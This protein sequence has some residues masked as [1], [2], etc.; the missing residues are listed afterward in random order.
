MA[1]S[2]TV[3]ALQDWPTSRPTI[4]P[5]CRREK[6]NREQKL[7]RKSEFSL[8]NNVRGGGVAGCQIYR[9]PLSLSWF[10]HRYVYKTYV[11]SRTLFSLSKHFAPVL[12]S[13]RS[14]VDFFSSSCY[15]P[16]CLFLRVD[17]YSE[18]LEEHELQTAASRLLIKDFILT[19]FIIL[20]FSV[21]GVGGDV[22]SLQLPKQSLLRPP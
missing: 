21:W 7:G 5:I 8:V 16:S 20:F 22:F 4:G 19:F 10:C 3:I 13:S 11:G 15:N 12:D 18:D 2:I 14:F 1:R 9:S 6:N 17:F